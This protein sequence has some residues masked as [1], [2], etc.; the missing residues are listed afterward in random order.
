M[1]GPIPHALMMQAQLLPKM[2]GMPYRVTVTVAAKNG[3]C[4]RAATSEVHLTEGVSKGLP[5]LAPAL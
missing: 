2:P 1:I 3:C 5:V 4:D